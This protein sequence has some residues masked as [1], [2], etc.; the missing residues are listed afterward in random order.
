MLGPLAVIM[1]V[2]WGRLH[3]ARDDDRGMTTEAMIITAM[4]A[5]AAIGAVTVI[6][7]AITNKGNAISDLIG[8]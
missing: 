7:T 6:A 8:G 3:D 4:L 5:V 2:L 1:N